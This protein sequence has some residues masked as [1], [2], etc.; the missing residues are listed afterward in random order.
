[1]AAKRIY[2]IAKEFE[3][4]EKKIIDFLMTQ[5]IKVANRLSAVSED[6]YNLLKTKLFA[7]PPPPPPPPEPKPEPVVEKPAQVAPPSEDASATSEETP[8]PA[9]KKKK[10]KKK[11]AQADEQADEQ[12]DLELEEFKDQPVPFMSSSN[13]GEANALTQ[14]VY[15]AA[16]TAGNA[17]IERYNPKS[18]RVRA[19]LTRSLD[20]WWLMQELKFDNPDSAPILYWQ[21]VNKLTTKAYKLLQQYGLNNRELLAEMRETV[22]AVGLKYEPQ[23]IFT[24]EENQRFEA[25]QN[26]LFMMFGHGMG[27]VNDNLYELKMYAERK[28]VYCE[29]MSFVDYLTN[30]ENKLE[31]KV[32]M[33][34]NAL[35]ETVAYSIRSVPCHVDFYR[36]NKDQIVRSIQNFFEWLEGYKKLK[37]QGAA[38]DKLE[39]YLKLEEK[40]FSMVEFMSLD[41]L[42]NLRRNRKLIPFDIVLDLLNEY[43]DNMDDPDAERNFQYK[44]RGVTNIIHKPKEYIFLYQLAELEPHKDYR[45]PEMIAA[46]EAKKA[47]AE[48]EKAAAEAAAQAEK[49]NPAA[50]ADEA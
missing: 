23:E 9:K 14:A 40:F 34:F 4:D 50:E 17:F 24:D 36:E 48:A 11:P 21:A 28:K 15:G 7:P 6:T 30:P 31:L 18:K 27:K 49:E 3:C 16:I 43:R 20:A 25:Q 35:A 10:K 45:T 41:N 1:M 46:D 39:K 42:I 2:Q 13:A 38:A 29:H 47:A 8:A 33:P 37:E 12:A 22:K 5:G 26:A 44:V 32:P 19:H